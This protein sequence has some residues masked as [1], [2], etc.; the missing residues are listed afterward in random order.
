M[1]PAQQ[2]AL[3]DELKNDPLALGYAAHLN[4][5]DEASLLALL[6]APNYPLTGSV[7]TGTLLSWLAETGLMAIVEDTA[8][9]PGSTYYA[10]PLR[11]AA[12]S[13]LKMLGTG[14]V[15]DL[16]GSTVGQKNVAMLAAWVTANALSTTDRDAL[17]ALA[18]V[19]SSRVQVLGIGPVSDVDVRST[20]YSATGAKVI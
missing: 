5:Y 2:A 6:N 18:A 16:S 1:T 8:N 11:S 9:T 12:L 7:T 14:I 15:F 17:L 19:P 4:P 20:V 3:A 10:T 13:M